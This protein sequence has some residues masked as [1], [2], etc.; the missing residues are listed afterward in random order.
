[1]AKSKWVS[2]W[3]TVSGA[4]KMVAGSGVAVLG[5]GV[6]IGRIAVPPNMGGKVLEAVSQ[7]V[8]KWGVKTVGDGWED[9]KKLEFLM[10]REVAKP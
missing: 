7:D 10:E 6:A 5:V 8:A 9:L 3:E 1:M 2:A 4:G